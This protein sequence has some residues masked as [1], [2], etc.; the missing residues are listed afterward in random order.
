MTLY[1][2]VV[3]GELA[4]AHPSEPHEGTDHRALPV[5]LHLV[6]MGIGQTAVA[7]VTDY[8]FHD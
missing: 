5:L 1:F 2:S 7:L 3:K 4:V 6:G 8:L